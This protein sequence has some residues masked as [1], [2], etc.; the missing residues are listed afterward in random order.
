MGRESEV[1]R[2]GPATET[3]WEPLAFGA[4]YTS[5]WVKMAARELP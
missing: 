1:K 5:S 4:V 3:F 2:Y